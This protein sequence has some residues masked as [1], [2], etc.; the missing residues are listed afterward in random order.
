MFS[1]EG[2]PDSSRIALGEE[3]EKRIPDKIA[4]LVEDLEAKKARNSDG[5]WPVIWDFAGQAVFRAIHPIFMSPAG[6][7]ILVFDLTKELSATAQC[8]VREEGCDEVEIAA[9]DSDDT[10]LDHIMRWMDLVHS[11]KHFDNEVLP[12][13]LLV[14]T[15]ADGVKGDCNERI[16]AL[17]DAFGEGFNKHI[18]DTFTVDNTLAGQTLNDEHPETVRLRQ[19]VLTVADEMPHTKRKVP[20]KWLEVEDMVYSLKR[21]QERNYITRQ[22]FKRD[23]V[24]KIFQFE[25]ENDLEVLLHFLHDRGAIVYHDSGGNPHGLVVLDPQWLIDVIT[26]VI[27]VKQQSKREKPR[28]RGLRKDLG[29]KGILDAE[30]LDYACSTLKLEKTHIKESLLLIMKKFNLLCECKGKDSRPVYLV[31]CMLKEKP[32]DVLIGQPIPGCSPVYIKSVD[33]SYVPSGLFSRL[34]VF[35]GEWAASK[36][37]CTEQQFYANAARFVIGKDVFVGFVCCKTVI[38]VHIWAMDGS[39]PV[40]KEPDVCPE[41]LR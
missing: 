18:A 39:N 5:I 9:P 31:P 32:K 28:I 3:E 22:E 21:S 16:D 41:F 26:S 33:T 15:H 2:I 20:L 13:V 27:S 12:P 25:N 29:E 6:V 4:K 19:E 10:N 34:L 23:I 40:Q 8:R 36:T 14:G 24:D 37:S 30:L 38:K 11:L 1:R 7:Y 17:L 35:F